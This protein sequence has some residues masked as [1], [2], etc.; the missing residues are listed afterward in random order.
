MHR[1]SIPHIHMD[2]ILI[3]M[4]VGSFL[5]SKEWGTQNALSV[6]VTNNVFMIDTGYA[7]ESPEIDSSSQYMMQV[8]TSCFVSFCF[9]KEHL[10]YMH[11]HIYR[12]LD[13]SLSCFYTFNVM[14]ALCG[15]HCRLHFTRAQIWAITV[16]SAFTHY[17]TE[18]FQSPEKESI[19]II[20]PLQILLVVSLFFSRRAISP[21]LH[22]TNK[23]LRVRRARRENQYSCHSFCYVTIY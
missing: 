8:P 13:N 3:L 22:I 19:V 12:A 9:W 10:I 2:F 23:E 14:H 15:R 16:L 7:E 21:A 20:S 5:G 11:A 4:L 1:V 17:T 6:Q 18:C